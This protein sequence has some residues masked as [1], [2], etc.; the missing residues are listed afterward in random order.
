MAIVGTV[1]S[2]LV[3]LTS[4]FVRVFLCAEFLGAAGGT[5]L[6]GEWLFPQKV[7]ITQLQFSEWLRWFE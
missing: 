1:I 3:A 5:V 7:R 2:D 6:H 4:G